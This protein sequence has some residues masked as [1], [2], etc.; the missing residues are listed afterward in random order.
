MNFREKTKTSE[1]CNDVQRLLIN[2]SSDL[3]L[4]L[5][6]IFKPEIP[7]QKDFVHIVVTSR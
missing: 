2:R 1:S 3:S 5:D 4:S 7:K 6:I